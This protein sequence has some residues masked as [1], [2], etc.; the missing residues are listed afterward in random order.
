MFVAIFVFS[1]SV[2]LL[3]SGIY[4][5]INQICWINGSPTGC[6]NS[7]PHSHPDVP[8]NRGDHAYLYGVFFFYVFLWS[9][10]FFMF[11]WNC[12]MHRTLV[13]TN[14]K[15]VRWATSQA[16]LYSLAF[17]FTWFP[18]TLWSFFT[19]A[20]HGAGFGIDILATICE[21]LHGLCNMLIFIRN[22]PESQMRLALIFRCQCWSY[23]PNYEDNEDD[24]NQPT[25]MKEDMDGDRSYDDLKKP[26]KT[27]DDVDVDPGWIR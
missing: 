10:I 26:N 23:L 15:D 22:R 4:N 11:Y 25:I 6:G 5:P 14:S 3:E 18:R 7:S 9:I 1:T 16:L 20:K 17:L 24:T 13:R 19:W 12:S 8:C 21:P 2:A 27:D